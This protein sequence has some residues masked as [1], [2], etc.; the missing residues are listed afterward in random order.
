M[1]PLQVGKLGCM[2]GTED[3]LN[4]F[5]CL[6]NIRIFV[7]NIQ[8]TDSQKYTTSSFVNELIDKGTQS[9]K[10]EHSNDKF[11]DL[12]IKNRLVPYGIIIVLMVESHFDRVYKLHNKTSPII[13]SGSSEIEFLLPLLKISK[14]L[15]D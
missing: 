3:F 5:Q 13:P 7:I 14:T 2:W 9:Y 8:E 10:E 15:A 12:S 4:W 1:T 6:F 11:F